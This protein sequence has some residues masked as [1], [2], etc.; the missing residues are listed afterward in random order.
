M[1]RSPATRAPIYPPVLQEELTGKTVLLVGYGAIGKEIERMLQPF[2][3]NML[4]V[5]RSA[6]SRAGGSRS[7]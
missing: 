3:V 7:K 5:A 4:R 2:D 1:R 6:R